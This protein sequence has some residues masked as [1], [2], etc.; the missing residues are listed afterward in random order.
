MKYHIDI[1]LAICLVFLACFSFAAGYLL[2]VVD[3]EQVTV[4][5][6]QPDLDIIEASAEIPITAIDVEG[7]GSVSFLTVEIVEGKGRILVSIN[8]VLAGT[9]TQQ[10][11]I[12]ATWAAEYY[13]GVDF[14]NKD[15][16]YTIRSDAALLSGP[17]A[18]AAMATALILVAENIP[19]RSDAM[20]TGTISTDGT[21]GFVDGIVAKATAAQEYGAELFLVPKGQASQVVCDHSTFFGYCEDVSIEEQAG[22]EVEEVSN[23]AEAMEYF[24]QINL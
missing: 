5:A 18:G 14:S 1:V 12:V 11:A 19:I 23:L 9:D 3:G 21:I 6:A 20:I 15:I 16:I 24:Y 17:S 13:L 2:N 10:S 22:I 7:N 8:D 4:M